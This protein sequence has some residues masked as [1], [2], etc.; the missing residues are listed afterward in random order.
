MQLIIKNVGN[1]SRLLDGNEVLKERNPYL[2]SFFCIRINV[3]FARKTRPIFTPF[4]LL[5]SLP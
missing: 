2:S 1:V 4:L 5:I 3:H